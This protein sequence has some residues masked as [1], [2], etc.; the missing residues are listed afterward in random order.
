VRKKIGV[1]LAIA[2]CV[3]AARPHTAAAQGNAFLPRAGGATI[4]VSQTFEYYDEFWRGD[5]VVSNPGLGRV[6]TGSATV[7]MQAGLTD[8]LAL[9]A[10]FA[11]VD[12]RSDGTDG[13][14][15]QGLQDRAFLLRWRFLDTMPGGWHHSLVAGAG[16][17]MPASGYDP[18]SPVALGD[19]TTDGLFRLVYQAQYDAFWGTYLAVEA[20]YD[21]R[22]SA[23][24]DGASLRGE[25]G[26]TFYRLSLA[27]ILHATWA[28][29]GSDI[30]D[31]GFT[32]PGLNEEWVRLA[33][34]A[35]YRVSPTFGLALSGFTVLD[36]RNTGRSRGV[37][38]SLVVNL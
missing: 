37:S 26:A 7:W 16:L 31:P 20:G 15:D 19:G 35:Y 8:D 5:E 12:V 30:G 36:G 18:N 27:G 33:G 38:T 25:L 22:E 4:A 28:D 3:V 17:R 29:G 1:W 32:F 21:A 24:P 34:N 13:L 11:Y 6:E 9:A 10:N 14:A 23:A 2:G